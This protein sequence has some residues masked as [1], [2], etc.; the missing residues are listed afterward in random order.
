MTQQEKAEFEDLRNQ[1]GDLKNQLRVTTEL[2][3]TGELL[4]ESLILKLIF[5][6][7]YDHLAR[8]QK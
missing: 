6:G 2:L 5:S 8:K 1:I 3:I 7:Y 4:R